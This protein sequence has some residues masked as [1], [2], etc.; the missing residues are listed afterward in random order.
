MYEDLTGKELCEAFHTDEKN[1]LR[2]K[3]AEKRLLCDGSNTLKTAKEQTLWDRIQNQI[4]DP[5]IFILF[6]AASISM[7][8]REYGDTGIIL[9]VIGLNTTVGVIQEGK[10]RKALEALKKMT[11]PSAVVKRDGI[12]ERIP[13]DKLVKGDMVKLKA[14]DQVPA[15]IRLLKAQELSANESALTGESMPVRKSQEVIPKG[16][17][18][19]EKKNMM[20]MST[21]V[22]KGSGEGIVVATGMNTEL[23]KIA[24]MIEDTKQEMTPLQKRLGDLGKILSV[25]AV[26]LCAGLFFIGVV[27]HRNLLQMLLLAISLAVAAIPEG[28]PAVV[29]IVLAL[30]VG[31]MVKINAII[32]RLPAVETLGAVGVVCSDKTG[33]LT[34]N[35][36]TV[37]KIYADE[38]ILPISTI[39]KREFPKLMEGFLLCNN[40]ILGKQEIGDA[41]ELALLHTGK[42]MGYDERRLQ[43]QYLRT[44]EIPFNS[45]KKY[46]VSVHKDGSHEIAYIKG[47]CDYVLNQCAYVENHGRR[48][49]MTQMEKMKIRRAMEEM[50]KEGLRILALAYKDRVVSKTEK[51]LTEG[52]VFAGMAGMLDPPRKESAQS[53]KTL[54]QAGVQVVMIT[55]DYKDTAFSIAKKI[56][57]ADCV[58]QCITGQEMDEMSEG[59]LQKKM[60]NLRVFAR[61]TPAHKVRIVKGFQDNGQ[62]VAMTGDGVNDAPS[63]QKADIGIAMGKNG[64][65]AAKNAA[66]MVLSDDNFSTIEKA[67]EEGRGIY[68]NIKKSILFLLSSNFG[69]I[70]T[71]FA[72]VLFQLPTPLKASHILWVNL[73]TDSLP[74]L[75]LGIDKNDSEALMR[76][77]PRNPKEGLF[78]HGG[79]RF[80][81]FYGVLIAVITLYAFYLGGQT[82]AFTVLGI[83][84]LFHAIGMRDREKSVFQMKQWENP[85][86]MIAFFLGLG[87]QIMVTEIPYFVQLFGTTCLSL[88]EWGLLLGISA[89]P[90]VLHEFFI[91]L[92]KIGK[93]GDRK[94][95]KI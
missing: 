2:A 44:F 77:P 73:I 89:M 7:L 51:A 61:V 59:D 78:A 76:K 33:T 46:M 72:A 92:S 62:I 18:I 25:V 48:K 67:M 71:M 1:G 16:L 13:A 45:E 80:T 84:Q 8:L 93:H 34:E 57:I 3:E 74:A 22:M 6:L 15:D 24:G 27:Q 19:A 52:L 83:S 26:A 35:K 36:M 30:G 60:K 50:A 9:V 68:V 39:R 17:P 64:T 63:L 31:R 12:Y 90:L 75:A 87:L 11:A 29:T 32:R 53:V 82:Y 69:E 4:N 95:R 43:Q 88:Q 5:M 79:W 41:T 21:E 81:I 91:L 54:K 94:C 65:D 70:I 58:E 28:L 49:P 14:G 47:A 40:S 20:Y 86:M 38:K 37:T 10:A 56:G 42:N 85:F 23:G 55:G 66:D